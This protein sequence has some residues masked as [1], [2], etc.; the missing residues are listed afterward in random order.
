MQADF[1]VRNRK[2]NSSSSIWQLLLPRQRL[3]LAFVGLALAAILI[4]FPFLPI[5]NDPLQGTAGLQP[6]D[7]LL[8]AGI[9]CVIVLLVW[10]RRHK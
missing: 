5:A 4:A 2:A 3:T 10:V 8:L 9:L 7:M 1:K 6:Q